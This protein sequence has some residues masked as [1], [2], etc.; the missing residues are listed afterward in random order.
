LSARE[1]SILVITAA[2]TPPITQV[3]MPITHGFVKN[4]IIYPANL[5]PNTFICLTLQ[6]TGSKKA[7]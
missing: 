3:P 5:H 7:E 2:I 1:K 6:I 4:A